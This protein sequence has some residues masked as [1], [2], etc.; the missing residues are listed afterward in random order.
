MTHSAEPSPMP[1]THIGDLTSNIPDTSL[2]HHDAPESFL[3][4]QCS[5]EHRV[6]RQG[7]GTH[8]DGSAVSLQQL[9][10]QPA[11]QRHTAHNT[12]PQTYSSGSPGQPG[13]ASQSE[14]WDSD[15]LGHSGLEQPDPIHQSTTQRPTAP[16]TVGSSC[17]SST[18]TRGH[19][20]VQRVQFAFG[21]AGAGCKARGHGDSNRVQ[22]GTADARCRVCGH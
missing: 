5:G 8:T 6:A 1:K 18:E 3:P 20:D 9:R 2:S 19:R 15:T 16:F 22:F 12:Q 7:P 14:P 21:T 17:Q 10:Q 11:P 13:P 4:L